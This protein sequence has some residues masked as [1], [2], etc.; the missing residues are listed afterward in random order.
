[1]S[2][3]AALAAFA[4]RWV[5]SW[6]SRAA[7]S[8]LSSSVSSPA[9]A[10]RLRSASRASATSTSSALMIPLAFAALCATSLRSSVSICLRSSSVRRPA[11]C[12]L[13][14]SASCASAASSSAVLSSSEAE[15]RAPE[16]RT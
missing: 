12:R 9:A 14:S 13:R 5:A 8:R 6:R 11:A 15:P 3:A 4:V 7:I 2:L 10:R 16:L 1:M